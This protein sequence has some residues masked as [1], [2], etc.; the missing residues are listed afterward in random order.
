MVWEAK[1]ICINSSVADTPASQTKFLPFSFCCH[2]R[3]LHRLLHIRG[4]DRPVYF[5]E[6]V[7]LGPVK[8]LSGFGERFHQ[9]LSCHSIYAQ[10]FNASHMVWHLLVDLNHQVDGL[11][12]FLNLS[13]RLWSHIHVALSPIDQRD[14]LQTGSDFFDTEQFASLKWNETSQ[15][16]GRYYERIAAIRGY[17][18]DVSHSVLR[19]GR[20]TD[21]H[22]STDVCL[23][24]P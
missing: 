14:V 3:H 20:S 5:E 15:D 2:A 21:S 17:D 23:F 7:Q 11:A 4:Q 10:K 18:S 12:V 22:S 13:V 1:S 9:F 6:F 19:S 16:L 8:N 24:A